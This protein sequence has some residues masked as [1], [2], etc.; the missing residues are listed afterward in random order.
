[1][2]TIEELAYSLHLGSD[3]NKKNI[4]K[5]KAKENA[6]G[7]TSLSNNAI[8]NLQQLSK[9]DKHN[10]RKY[11]NDNERI[12]IV[13]GTTSCYQDTK[14]LY[15]EIFEESRKRYNEKQ[16]REDRKINDYM[17]DI[18][19]N[20]KKDLACEIIIE[21]GNKLYWEDKDEIFWKKMSNVYKK[22]VED[23]EMLVPNFKISSAV[24]HYDESSPH[25]HIVGIPIKEKNKYGMELQVGKSDVFTKESL[26][27]LQDKMRILCIESFNKEYNLNNTLKEKKKGRNKDIHVKDMDNYLEMQNQI[28]L[29]KN[30]LEEIDNKAQALDN[31]SNEVNSIIN[32]LKKAPLSKDKYIIDEEEK[33]KII[34]YINNVNETNNNYKSMKELSITLNNVDNDLKECRNTITVLEQNNKALELRN[35]NLKNDNKKLKEKNTLL[36]NELD[37]LK[38]LFEKFKKKINDLYVF[39]RDKMWGNK[40]KRDKYYPIAYE[41]YG[42]NI[43]DNDQMQV[44]HDTKTR[45]SEMDS[46]KEKDDYEIS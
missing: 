1:M 31:N 27:K 34:N 30:K 13:K 3:K 9:V 35:T 43:F 32:N 19:D 23:L 8:Q 33:D 20:N 38:E 17:K 44:I 37:N 4:S 11:D 5:E 10:Y 24:I 46:N 28:E 39:F 29:N 14:D 6:S 40:E 7:T 21:L 2:I 25:M 36:Q 22:Q 41:L 45:S 18:S 16:V 26:N 42:K 12:E 15:L